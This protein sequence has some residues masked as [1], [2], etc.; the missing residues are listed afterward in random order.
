MPDFLPPVSSASQVLGP[1]GAAGVVQP[2]AAFQICAQVSDQGNPP[3]GV[4]TVTAD[5]TAISGTAAVPL[6]VATCHIGSSTYNYSSA[7][8]TAEPGLTVGATLSYTLHMTDALD[9][10]AAQSY[11]ALVQ[12]SPPPTGCSGSSITA[13]NGGAAV[14]QI[15]SGDVILF[16]FTAPIDKQSIIPGWTGNGAAPPVT[17]RVTNKGNADAITVV[18][19]GG[20]TSLGKIA[21]KANFVE[22]GD[23]EFGGTLTT[24]GN[25]VRLSVDYKSGGF[26]YTVRAPTTAMTWTPGSGLRDT[27]GNPCSTKKVTQPADVANF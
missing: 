15:D 3:A 19:N 16:G 20:D 12:A 2:G 14:Q 23:V 13:T 25:N 27:S 17:I 26:G 9:Q 22:N 6:S 1:D 7:S 18:Y 10:A 11:T 4:K 8:Q 24:T 21:T 5:A